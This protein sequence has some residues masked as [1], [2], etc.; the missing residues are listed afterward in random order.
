MLSVVYE[1]YKWALCA[2]CRYTE[3]HY[4]ECRGVSLQPLKLEKIRTDMESLEY[5][6]IWLKFMRNPILFNKINLQILLSS[7]LFYWVNSPYKYCHYLNKFQ[8]NSRVLVN[9]FS[10]FS[11]SASCVLVYLVKS[12]ESSRRGGIF[13]NYLPDH[14]KE[15]KS[16]RT[17]AQFSLFESNCFSNWENNLT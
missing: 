15:M 3:C 16:F 4:A 9:C 11:R 13:T 1:C 2:E 10:G 8:E 14:W 5:L 6:K 7:K 12:I 17:R